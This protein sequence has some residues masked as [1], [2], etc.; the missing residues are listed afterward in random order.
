[1]KCKRHTRGFSGSPVL[2]THLLKTAAT[3][4]LSNY[5]KFWNLEQFVYDTNL[6]FSFTIREV[7]QSAL[8]G[9]WEVPE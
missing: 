4:Y 2:R 7:P 8:Q 1:M 5:L 6:S 3:I 9:P